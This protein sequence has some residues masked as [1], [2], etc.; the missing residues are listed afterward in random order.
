MIIKIWALLSPFFN[1]LSWINMNWKTHHLELVAHKQLTISVH[2]WRHE[3]STH[4]NIDGN[5]ASERWFPVS[6]LYHQLVVLWWVSTYICELYIL[7]NRRTAFSSP[8]M[9]LSPL[10]WVLPLLAGVSARVSTLQ[11]LD[12][13][14]DRLM[15][16][17]RLFKEYYQCLL[18]IGPCNKDTKNFK[19]EVLDI[20]L[21]TCFGGLGCS[22]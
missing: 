15:E 16:D 12:K 18:D 13:D 22:G 6:C 17:E 3:A 9:Q 8:D 4:P 19:G 21:F 11:D 20:H 1:F 5:S 7:H 10:W 2:L 14:L